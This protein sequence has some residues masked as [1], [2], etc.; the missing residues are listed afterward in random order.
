MITHETLGLAVAR[1]LAGVEI[2]SNMHPFVLV[3]VVG[4]KFPFAL[5]VDPPPSLDTTRVHFVS[6]FA[7][8]SFIAPSML[9][10]GFA[11]SNLDAMS[12]PVASKAMNLSNL[13]FFVLDQQDV[14]KKF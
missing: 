7:I 5:V 1:I 3:K 14:C 2:I 11:S 8:R 12:V 10:R 6:V 9:A 13:T 4:R